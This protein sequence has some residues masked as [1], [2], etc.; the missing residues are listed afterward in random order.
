VQS[1]AGREVE[2]ACSYG[3][4]TP[5]ESS[6]F[7]RRWIPAASQQN[8]WDCSEGSLGVDTREREGFVRAISS[9]GTETDV[10]RVAPKDDSRSRAVLI[11]VVAAYVLYRN[12]ETLMS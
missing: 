2:A 12:G 6:F 11:F 5:T 3:D 8:D 7:K 4:D 10:C 1:R 9:L